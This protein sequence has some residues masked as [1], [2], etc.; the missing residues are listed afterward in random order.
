MFVCSSAECAF[1]QGPDD[2]LV[3]V[4]WTRAEP[5]GLYIPQKRWGIPNDW[6]SAESQDQIQSTHNNGL[7]TH[8]CGWIA[9]GVLCANILWAVAQN[10][11]RRMKSRT[12][13]W[14]PIDPYADRDGFSN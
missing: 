4:D 14:D 7:G 5:F 1:W 11:C 2:V 9:F 12:W 8:V 10:G 6:L 3:L 13:L